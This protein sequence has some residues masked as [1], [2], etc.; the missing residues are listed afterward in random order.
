MSFKLK[1]KE[2][3]PEGIR[4]VVCERIDRAVQSLDGNGRRKRVRDEAVHEA[5]KRFKQVRGALRMVQDELG[6][7]GF[8]REN[9]TFRDAGHR[10]H[11]VH[12]PPTAGL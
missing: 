11:D 9:R 10:G 12:R 8:D 3:V 7:K 1:R 2:T 5:R 6:E 4:R